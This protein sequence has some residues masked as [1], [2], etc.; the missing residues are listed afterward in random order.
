VGS[1]SSSQALKLS[2]SQALKLSIGL[3]LISLGCLEADVVDVERQQELQPAVLYD[4]QVENS[5]TLSCDDDGCETDNPVSESTFDHEESVWAALDA[6]YSRE[7][8]SRTS[9]LELASRLLAWSEV[10]D[11]DLV[12][13]ISLEDPDDWS[14]PTDLADDV[15]ASQIE[16]RKARLK[17]SQDRVEDFITSQGGRVLHRFWLV[18]HVLIQLPKGRAL[19][20]SDL[21]G[22]IDIQRD[23]EEGLSDLFD[24]KYLKDGVRTAEY[25]QSGYRGNTGGPNGWDEIRVGIL[26]W[27]STSENGINALHC[28][29]CGFSNSNCN[30][31][32]VVTASR[33]TSSGCGNVNDKIACIYDLND[34]SARHGTSVTWAALGN[35][36]SQ[37]DSDF[38]GS[39]TIEQQRRGG[40]MQGGGIYYYQAS[41]TCRLKQALE[42][43]VEQGAQVVNMSIQGGSGN[44]SATYDSCGFNAALSSAFQNNGISLVG[45]AG[46]DGLDGFGVCHTAWPARRP[47]VVSVGALGAIGLNGVHDY[48]ESRRH[49]YSS[50]GTLYGTYLGGGTA[51]VN[52]VDVLAPGEFIN[53]FAGSYGYTSLYAFGTSLASPVVAGIAGLVR[54]WMYEI[55]WSTT[56]GTIPAMLLLFGD[57]YT[58]SVTT[59]NSYYSSTMSPASGAGRIRAAMI[60]QLSSGT[61][62]YWSTRTKT[63]HQGETYEW[64]IVSGPASSLYTGAKVAMFGVDSDFQ[65]IPRVKLEVVDKCPVGGG[66]QVVLTASEVN[67]ALRKKIR[68][69]SPATQIHGRCLYARMV[70]LNVPASGWKVWAAT[71]AYSNTPSLH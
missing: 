37:Q 17:P 12:L 35:I 32:K 9:P 1:E 66:T 16:D 2:S 8:E 28:L 46:N 52:L 51:G 60:N 45:G 36:D 10:E 29:H 31:L 23:E 58:G 67:G 68:L 33:C 61:P 53:M 34:Q 42:K 47:E 57:G 43:L 64:P 13:S 11:T 63:M 27:H 19:E 55:G 7:G 62:R 48:R 71:M 6:Q 14:I 59:P 50:H 56:A 30:G 44:C 65:N 69:T 18:N 25:R 5:N 26:E 3:V 38:P 24:G 21:P 54:N 4:F 49:P 70:G 20:L 15:R 41:G 22:V 40:V 39:N